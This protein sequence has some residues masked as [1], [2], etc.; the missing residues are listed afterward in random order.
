MLQ[1]QVLKILPAIQLSL[2]YLLLKGI[3]QTESFCRSFVGQS[4]TPVRGAKLGKNA[5]TSKV[6]IYI[7]MTY[8]ISEERPGLNIHVE[9]SSHNSLRRGG[10]SAALQ[11]GIARGYVSGGWISDAIDLYLQAN[12]NTKL[13]VTEDM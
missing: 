6:K 3:E 4:R 1:S 10:V 13:S 5:L 2:N 12:V 9:Q 11:N 7:S 8:Y